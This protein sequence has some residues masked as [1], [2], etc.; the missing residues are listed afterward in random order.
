MKRL[1]P[2]VLQCTSLSL[3]DILLQLQMLTLSTLALLMMLI[4]VAMKRRSTNVW[5]VNLV[6][7]IYARISCIFFVSILECR[8]HEERIRWHCY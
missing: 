5:S 7:T 1:L 6:R 8:A 2:V 4:V 3:E